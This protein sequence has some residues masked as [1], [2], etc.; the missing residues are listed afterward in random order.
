M[1]KIIIDKLSLPLVCILLLG[2]HQSAFAAPAPIVTSTQSDQAIQDGAFGIGATL[3]LTQRPFVGVGNQ[4]TLLPYFSYKHGNFYIESLDIGYTVIKQ[5]T[6]KLDAL[7]TPRF[8]EVKASFAKNGELNGIDQT[9]PTY[10]G[11]LSAQF[12]AGKT[13]ITAQV[14]HD[15]IESKGNEAVLTAS[16]AFV[17]S[18][19]LSLIPSIG[20]TYQDSKMVD[21][22]Y[23]VQA[24]EVAAGRPYYE[25]ESSI[26]Y[27][28]TL[29][30][31]YKWSKHVDLLGQVKFEALGSGI[32]NSPI[33]NRSTI[34]A[35][36]VGGVYRF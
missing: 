8:Y 5:S 15:L 36:T 33:V 28:A 14:F 34:F 11:G 4:L 26:N 22:F 27:N 9:N 10:M 32:K 30:G 6:V 2:T 12:R 35:I 17:T 21:Y 24:N 23:G 25:G 20:A 13:V 31:I 29:N 16:K 7:L 19:K 3:S 1:I 18:N